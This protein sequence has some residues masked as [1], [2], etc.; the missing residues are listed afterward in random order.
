MRVRSPFQSAPT[1]SLTTKTQQG[2]GT[3]LPRQRI[4][5]VSTVGEAERA[6]WW[7][8]RTHAASA[9]SAGQETGRPRA[10]KSGCA[11]RQLRPRH[12]CND[13]THM[14]W[15]TPAMWTPQNRRGAG[16][17]ANSPIAPAQDSKHT[18][19]ARLAGPAAAGRARAKPSDEALND[20]PYGY[21]QCLMGARGCGGGRRVPPRSKWRLHVWGV[22]KGLAGRDS[23]SA[24]VHGRP[25]P[26]KRAP[27][28]RQGATTACGAMHNG[29]PP[30]GGCLNQ[31]SP[32]R[33]V[34][35]LYGSKKA[36]GGCAGDWAEHRIPRHLVCVV[37]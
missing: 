15:S 33:P 36:G 6:R 25:H 22:P 14:E 20:R 11:K 12:R 29:T 3:R 2:Q 24:V 9:L 13:T 31:P 34:W 37:S 8:A 30:P 19:A 35:G 16:G 32:L 10:R 5:Q 28:S 18:H 7:H 17:Q 1:G 4:F 26:T 23:D 27:P 21:T